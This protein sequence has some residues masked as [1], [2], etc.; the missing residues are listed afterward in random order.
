MQESLDLGARPLLCCCLLARGSLWFLAT[1]DTTQ[2]SPVMLI[3]FS[4]R[5]T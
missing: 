5:M 2:I 3:R 4:Y 1:K